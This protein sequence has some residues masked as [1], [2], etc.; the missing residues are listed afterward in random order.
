MSP[1]SEEYLI[2]STLH[3]S[4]P[5]IFI[6]MIL[7]ILVSGTRCVCVCDLTTLSHA[8]SKVACEWRRRLF[9]ILSTTSSAWIHKR[10]AEHESHA[11]C[12]H[13]LSWI[14]IWTWTLDVA[15]TWMNVCEIMPTLDLCL[16]VF[17]GSG[18]S[19]SLLST[20][21]SIRSFWQ[22]NSPLVR[23][24]RAEKDYIAKQRWMLSAAF[25]TFYWNYTYIMLLEYQYAVYQQLEST[26]I[27]LGR[28][29]W[30]MNILWFKLA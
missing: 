24:R 10:S 8:S 2:C 16:S 5:S 13:T 27:T 11:I 23:K 20:K 22:K 4:V 12:L 17:M 14:W 30:S 28:E 19:Y 21:F 3:G 9:W 26:I 1:Q 6:E 7:N 18:L 29:V 15:C 25:L